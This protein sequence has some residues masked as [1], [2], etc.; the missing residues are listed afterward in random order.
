[1]KTRTRFRRTLFIGL[2]LMALGIVL[3]VSILIA[4]PRAQAQKPPATPGVLRMAI[5]ISFR[6][7]RKRVKN[8]ASAGRWAA[9]RMATASSYGRTTVASRGNAK[10]KSARYLTSA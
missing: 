6:S 7:S 9:R 5:S 10:G 2:I 3:L 1:M 8:T 4:P